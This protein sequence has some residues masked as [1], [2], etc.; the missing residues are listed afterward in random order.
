MPSLGY[1]TV[2]GTSVGLGANFLVYF[3]FT[4]GSSFT[5]SELHLYG[6]TSSG[7]KVTLGIY[8]DN[9]GAP[10]TLLGETGEVALGSSAGW[11]T[12]ALDSGVSIT[13]GTAYWLAL[14]ANQSYTLYYDTNS[15]FPEGYFSST[16]TAGSLPSTA[17]GYTQAQTNEEFSIY[18]DNS[19]SAS[20]SL[21][22][23]NGNAL[24]SL[25]S[26]HGAGTVTVKAL[27]SGT[28]FSSG[29]S[30][31][32][33]GVS[34]WSVS[35]STFVDV[36][37][38]T[39]VLNCPAAAT[40]PAGATGTLS[41]NDTTDSLSTTISISTPTLS[42][43]P[44]SGGTGTT[45]TVHG[46]GTNTLWSDE[47]TSGLVTVSGGSGA[48][49]GTP[50]VTSNTADSFTLTVG[51]AGGT[52][53]I[54]DTSTGATASFTASAV[55]AGTA[56]LSSAT[57]STITV[58][59]GAAS[60]GSTPYSY[61]WHRSTVANF[62]PGAGNVL[63]GATTLTYADSTSLSANTPY[64]YILVVTDN[65]SNTA[66]SN[67]IAGELLSATQSFGF[68]GDSITAG[69][70]LSAG[71]DPCTQFGIL[72]K[73]WKTQ[74]TVNVSNQG[75]TGS[76]TAAWISGSTNLNTAISAFGGMSPVPTY[77]HVMLGTNDAAN[78]V[79]AATYKSNLQSMIGALQTAG[80]KVILSYP[81]YTAA[82]ANSGAT[83]QA[84]TAFCL[85]YQ[86]QID[87]LIDGVVVF[88]GDK[89]GYGYFIDKQGELQAD[90][91]HPTATG[92]ISLATMWML[93]IDRVANPSGSAGGGFIIG[94]SVIAT[95]QIVG[96]A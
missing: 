94:S 83:D 27:G 7:A 69:Y 34:G 84:A 45:P 32:V 31:S 4:A 36:T 86:A 70:G 37:H 74:E 8:S 51:S 68:I 13:N 52:L 12:A 43:S 44:T 61:Q 9:A 54:K 89:L 58:T 3:K 39:L 11:V 82:G 23:A 33:S 15:T 28:T 29:T 49:V 47:S 77:V 16:Y 50:T 79:S 21:T 71:Q 2:G 72:W 20:F 81:I 56:S 87:S 17:P 6:S 90:Q 66:Q 96:A 55:T 78:H 80:Y 95:G 42:L 75:V 10:G 53:T 18:A 48:S 63:S 93:A 73:K 65:A 57:S 24:S 40:P 41:V 35:S 19:G 91:T 38:F 76:A 92:D 30:W 14:N 5:A 64:F 46:T 1:T 67:Q 59:C 88:R 26:N 22:D 25:P 85:S 60:G 62:T